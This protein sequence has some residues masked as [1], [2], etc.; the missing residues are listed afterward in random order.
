MVS[1]PSMA[2]V[3][4]RVSAWMPRPNPSRGVPSTTRGRET[5]V[6]VTQ[7]TTISRAGSAP[8]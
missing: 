4:V 8:S 5:E 7:D 1:T 2:S 6:G 3:Q